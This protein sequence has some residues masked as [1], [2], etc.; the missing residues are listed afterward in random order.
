MLD[1]F[2]GWLR[3]LL[4]GERRPQPDAPGAR[5]LT[6][7]LMGEVTQ[8]RCGTPWSP[9]DPLTIELRRVTCPRCWAIGHREEIARIA[10]RR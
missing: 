1:R 5:K 6:M 8:S 10:K 2:F 3:S 4:P 7:H 9:A